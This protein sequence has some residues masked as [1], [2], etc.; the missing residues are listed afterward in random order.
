MAYYITYKEFQDALAD[1][2]NNKHIALQFS[3]M[4]NQLYSENRLKSFI[5]SPV[6]PLDLESLSKKE[7]DSLIEQTPFVWDHSLNIPENSVEERD[8]IP[9]DRDFHII[10]QMCYTRPS[11]HIHDYFE[12]NFVEQGAVHFCFED[13]ETT[14]HAGEIFIIS[15]NSKHD[16]YFTD[17]NTKHYS[18]SVRTSTFEAV[19]FELLSTQDV[20]A[21]F[22]RHTLRNHNEPN[23]L[24]FYVKN[25]D[26]YSNLIRHIFVECHTYD[27]YANNNGV[28]YLNIF[29]SHILRYNS[30][31]AQHYSYIE[32]NDPILILQYI[33]NNYA[34]ISLSF[35][36]EFFHY[37]ESYLCNLIKETTGR[38][39]SELI[40]QIRMRHAVDLLL[41][42][43]LKVFEIAEMI[44]Y[45][46]SDHF[47]RVF[48][49]VFHT[50][51]QNFRKQ[52][53]HN[54]NSV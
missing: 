26:F 9:N 6:F 54:V 21:Q 1:Y 31:S 17:E 38:T 19:F 12:I 43:D 36:S 11:L 39:Y 22:F 35:L 48:R 47:S 27:A 2:Y 28:N 41:K 33:Q 20:L 37:S 49:K 10:R 25:I 34:N 44:G 3:Q 40:R 53:D 29:L 13:S 52:N 18:I 16:I 24:K 42:T 46:S 4:M 8:M 51:P 7:F 15:P 45:S 32:K 30:Q 50:S 14:M 23:F 5:E